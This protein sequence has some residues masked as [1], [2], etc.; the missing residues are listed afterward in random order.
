MKLANS[1]D[2]A[3]EKK[4]TL[5]TP[6]YKASDGISLLRAAVVSDFKDDKKFIGLIKKV[7]N[8][9]NSVYKYMEKNYKGWD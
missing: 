8:D 3:S 2:E 4:G 5:R 6:Y 1:L 7:E 9:L